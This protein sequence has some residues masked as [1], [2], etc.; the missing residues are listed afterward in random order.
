MSMDFTI[1]LWL[2]WILVGFFFGLGWQLANAIY[3]AIP[4][5]WGSGARSH[6]RASADDL[7]A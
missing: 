7:L 1:Y 3:T 6:E 2:N 4:G 5:S